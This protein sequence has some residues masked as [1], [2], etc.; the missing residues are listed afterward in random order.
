MG[1][2]SNLISYLA[3]N[4]PFSAASFESVSFQE[5]DTEIGWCNVALM[6]EH[7]A[8]IIE[9]DV[10]IDWIVYNVIQDDTKLVHRCIM[11]KDG[12]SIREFALEKPFSVEECVAIIKK[13]KGEDV[14]LDI[15]AKEVVD[16]KDTNTE[17][18]CLSFGEPGQVIV[19][20]TTPASINNNNEILYV[21]VKV[22]KLLM[23]ML[24][25]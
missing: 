19:H 2:N 4:T 14:Q 16:T 18:Q 8:Y 11:H 15:G 6:E 17:P 7:N 9:K 24:H 22:L 21:I 25:M 3:E 10:I 20:T 1:I 5:I 13:L 23:M 12:D